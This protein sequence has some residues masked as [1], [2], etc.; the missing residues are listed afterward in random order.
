MVQQNVQVADLQI[1]S[2]RT[3]A[4]CVLIVVMVNAPETKLAI[5]CNKV[6][7]LGII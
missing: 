1:L 6:A 5:K 4:S 3:D 7:G 2:M